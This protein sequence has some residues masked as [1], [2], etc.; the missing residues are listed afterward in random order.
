[1]DQSCPFEEPDRFA[2][3]V[4]VETGN[5]REFGSVRRTVPAIAFEKDRFVDATLAIREVRSNGKDVLAIKTN[6]SV[7]AV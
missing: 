5:P 3:M 4:D 1:M 6:E 7:G 2:N